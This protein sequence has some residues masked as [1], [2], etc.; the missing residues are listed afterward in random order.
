MAG[1][2]S[3]LG[4]LVWRSQGSRRPCRARGTVSSYTVVLRSRAAGLVQPFPSAAPVQGA[5]ARWGAEARLRGGRAAR[6]PRGDVHCWRGE[7]WGAGAGAVVTQPGPGAAPCPRRPRAEL[8]RGT[9]PVP[10]APVSPW[11]ST[12][13]EGFVWI[14]ISQL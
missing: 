12:G 10:C 5:L 4:V 6:S 13:P 2:T 14:C 7:I 1:S 9:A 8:L 11:S 3:A